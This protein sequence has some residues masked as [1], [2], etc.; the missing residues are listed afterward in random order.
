MRLW[1]V[2]VKIL[3]VFKVGYQNNTPGSAFRTDFYLVMEKY[4]C[5]SLSL[6][7]SPCSPCL[8]ILA[9]PNNNDAHNGSLFYNRE[10]KQIY[11]LKGS[12]RNRLVRGN[13]ENQVLMDEN[14]LEVISGNPLFIS[15]ESKALLYLCI[16]N[17]TLYT[18]FSPP[19][20]PLPR[21]H[22]HCRVVNA[23]FSPA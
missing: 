12:L 10:I 20:A 13:I 15:S 14:L 16:W 6:R 1:Q 22:T 7:C 8:Y 11:D 21:E 3:G 17:D 19:P 23:G 9:I 2:L 18:T 4:V 5:S